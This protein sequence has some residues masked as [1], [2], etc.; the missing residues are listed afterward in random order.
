MHIVELLI[1]VLTGPLLRAICL[2]IY[3]ECLDFCHP[4]NL[5]G[6]IEH[7]LFCIQQTY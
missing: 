4:S 1:C 6:N 5:T 7:A 3:N 2:D